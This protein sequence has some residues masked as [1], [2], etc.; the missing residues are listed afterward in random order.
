MPPPPTCSPSAAA[1]A[2]VTRASTSARPRAS[3]T[4]SSPAPGRLACARPATDRTATGRTA[5]GRAAPGRAAAVADPDLAF[6]RLAGEPGRG[7]LLVVGPS[8]G[9]SVDVLWQAA[10]DLLG[11]RFE[12]VGWDLPG[13][14]RSAP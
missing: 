10:A 12:V 2:T 4:P 11:E 14:G 3:S 1:R 9:T 13:H 5:T 6:T 7:D 8:L